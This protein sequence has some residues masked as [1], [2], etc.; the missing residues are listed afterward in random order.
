MDLKKLV[1]FWS[2][3]ELVKPLYRHPEDCNLPTKK[4]VGCEQ[5]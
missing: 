2:E 3:C 4:S 5:S 1:E